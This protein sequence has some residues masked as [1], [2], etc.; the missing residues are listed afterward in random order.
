MFP[1]QLDQSEK[2]PHVALSCSFLVA[3]LLISMS[4]VAKAEMR[5]A[6]SNDPFPPKNAQI[7]AT[8]ALPSNQ[9]VSLVS[10]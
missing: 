9:R 10:L 1:H 5:D 7:V 3:I 4:I 2:A 6:A 8:K